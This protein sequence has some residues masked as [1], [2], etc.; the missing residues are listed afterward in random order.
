MS[1]EAHGPNPSPQPASK[2]KPSENELDA[3]VSN[4]APTPDVRRAI[5]NYRNLS[6]NY[7]ETCRTIEGI[8]A[9]ALAQLAAQPGETIADVACGTGATLVQLGEA[10]GERGTVIGLE[11]STDMA[12]LAS[13]R[14]EAAGLAGRCQLRVGAIEGYR[15]RITYDALLFCYTHDVLQSP[16]ALQALFAHAR[17]GARVVAVG[18]RF[19]P[20][21][22]G[23]PL[24]LFTGY[25]ARRYLTTFRGL[26]EPWRLLMTYCPDF[27]I[28][29]SDHAG[30]SYLGVGTYKHDT[31]KKNASLHGAGSL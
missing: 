29:G 20:W 19:L 24:N 10:V 5:R 25:R 2:G 11:L 1:T 12:N 22:W 31:T 3:I 7:D 26:R 6:A 15:D 28:V 27:R 30:T 14:I 8:R 18:A 4:F 16:Q 21:W 17:D 23:F 9:R 13:Q